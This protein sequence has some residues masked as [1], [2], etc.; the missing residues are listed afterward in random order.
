MATRKTGRRPATHDA[1]K[2]LVPSRERRGLDSAEIVLP[3]DAPDVAPLAGEWRS[4]RRGDRR[5]P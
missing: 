4:R 3:L 2:R 1:R 5:V